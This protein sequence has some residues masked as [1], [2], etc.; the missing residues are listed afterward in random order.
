MS[1]PSLTQVSAVTL[2]WGNDRSYREGMAPWLVLA[3]AAPHPTP[4]STS[5]L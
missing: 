1:R 5:S 2:V 3:P 4:H